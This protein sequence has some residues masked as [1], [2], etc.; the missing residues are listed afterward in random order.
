MTR[1][2]PM[3]LPFAV[4]T[5]MS[6]FVGCATFQMPFGDRTL[7]ASATNP[8]VEIL[9]FWQ[10]GEGQDPDGN[11]C[12]GFLGNIL[13]LSRQSS[14]PVVIEGDVR[15]YLYDDHG[16]TEE[17]TKPIHQFDF[18]NASWA[19]HLGKT[20]LGP[21]YSVFVPYTKRGV[22]EARCT[23]R[24]RLKPKYGPTIYSDFSNLP[25]NGN[26]K[27]QKNEDPGPTTPDEASRV[28]AE[29]AV[30]SL[31]RTTTIPT[32]ITP[33]TTDSA[34]VIHET[35]DSNRVQQASHEVPSGP[36]SISNESE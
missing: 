23:L 28:A 7:K 5:L 12:K 31:L 4:M 35:K 30:A 24:V 9:C 32:G 21:T 2:S 14:A 18:D 10:H 15:I 6:S 17:Q 29:A 34:T 27:P 26:K 20:P 8:A 13:F 3:I 16:T 33:K 11:P 22:T 19:V 36:T 1:C 25:L